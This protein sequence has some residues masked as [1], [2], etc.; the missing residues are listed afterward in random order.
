MADSYKAF[1]DAA[2]AKLGVD[3]SIIATHTR[4][5]TAAGGTKAI[6]QFNYAN[7]KAGS[8]WGGSAVGATVPEFKDGKP[9]SEVAKFRS[10]ASP[11]EAAA[12]YARL[13]STR[14]PGAAGAKTPGDFV[15]ALVK[16]GYAT[17][18]NYQAKFLG[19]ASRTA[20]AG[21]RIAGP[22]A[23]VVE[24]QYGAPARAADPLQEVMPGKAT[25]AKGGPDNGAAAL[26]VLP[27]PREIKGT[28][29][30]AEVQAQATLDRQEA[31]KARVSVLE[32]ARR[33][34]AS[35]GI[36]GAV[37][38]MAA[39]KEVL[40]DNTPDPAFRLDPA[41]L[42]GTD[43]AE[44][45]FLSEA[46]NAK[47]LEHR[48]W[49]V[50]DRRE[51][52]KIVEARGAGYA[53]LA[54]AVSELPTSALLGAGIA[55][56]AGRLGLG[57]ARLLA[58]GRPGAAVGY[59]IGENA[60]ANAAAE[61]IQERIDPFHTWKDA[62]FNMTAGVLFDAALGSPTLIREGALGRRLMAAGE[63]HG[64]Q[65]LAAQ[66]AA[67]AAA[68]A[69]APAAH[70]VVQQQELR[71]SSLD[72]VVAEAPTPLFDA[73]AVLSEPRGDNPLLGVGAD[74]TRTAPAARPARVAGREWV[75][76]VQAAST[77]E[78]AAIATTFPAN[79]IPVSGGT[80][81]P[82]G[83]LA[84]YDP[85]TGKVYAKAGDPAAM[86]ADLLAEVGVKQRLAGVLGDEEYNLAL[87]SV[88][89]LAQR[90]DAIAKAAEAK[91]PGVD[92]L[93]REA[94]LA[95]YIRTSSETSSLTQRVLDTM[96][97]WW[98]KL[99][100]D[101][102]LTRTDLLALIE[103]SMQ[104]E[105]TSMV[106]YHGSPRLFDK[107]ESSKIGTGEG[108]IT[109]G[110]GLYFTQ[111]KGVA[112][113]YRKKEALARGL[114]EDAGTTYKVGLA[115]SRDEL[116][117]W[118]SASQ[119]AVVQAAFSELGLS[120]TGEQAYFSLMKRFSGAPAEQAKQASAVLR[121][122]GVKGN[123]Y[124]SAQGGV[125]NI[126]VFNADDVTIG[127]AFGNEE[128][129]RSLS[130]GPGILQWLRSLFRSS[131]E[132]HVGRPDY[133]WEGWDNKDVWRVREKQFSAGGKHEAV[134]GQITHGQY[135][136]MADLDVLP[137]GITKQAGK[138][139]SAVEKAA[140]QLRAKF[141]G[142]DFK[143]VLMDAD[144][145][146]AGA[147]GAI[148]MIREN[149][150]VIN[151]DLKKSK[152]KQQRVII[153]EIGHAVWQKYL[154]KLTPEMR[155]D[156]DRAYQE[157]RAADPKE[158]ARL[159]YSNTA[160]SA[161]F[162]LGQSKYELS[163]DEFSAE[164]FAKYIEDSVLNG[165]NFLRIDRTFADSLIDAVLGLIKFFK[166]GAKAFRKPADGYADMFEA[167][168]TKQAALNR[169][170]NAVGT[171]APAVRSKMEEPNLHADPDIQ[172]L[173]MHLFPMDT[174]Q[175]RAEVLAI[176]EL[177][178]KAETSNIQ[179]DEKRLSKLLDTA[180]FEDGQ[181][182]ANVLLRA[183]NPVARFVSATLLESPS[184][185]AGRRKTAAI[186]KALHEQAFLG[187]SMNEVQAAYRL[188]RQEAGGSVVEDT[189]G[190]K[191]WG[192]FNA[193]V[194]R[195]IEGRGRGA[196]VGSH[197]Q[198]VKAADSLE[199]A[200]ERMRTAQVQANTV[201]AG[202]LPS[203]SRGYM[204]HRLSQEKIR[205]A[206]TK[207]LSALH[208][209]LTDQFV[210][211]LGFDMSFA[212]ML[213]SKYIDRVKIRALGGAD[214]PAGMAHAGASDVV[215]EAL[216]AAGM[217]DAEVKA[218]LQRI[219]K[220]G[221]GHT[222]KRLQLDLNRTY[223]TPD[224]GT[225]RLGDLFETDQ[226]TLLRAQASRVSG[227]VALSEHGVPGKAG[228]DMIRR[229]LRAGEDGQQATLREVDAFDQVAAEFLGS[230]YG[231]QN[232]VIDRVLQANSLVR[233]GGLA[234]TQLS[235]VINGVVHLGVGRA[236]DSV[237]GIPR[238]IGEVHAL[239]RGEQ[240]NGVLSGMEKLYG[241]EFGTL[242]YKTVFPFDSRSLDP[243]SYGQD[244]LTFMD[245]LLRGGGHLQGK[246]SMWRAIHSAQHRG[247]AEQIA[248]KAVVYLQE[249][250]SA[251]VF[252]R[253]MG[254]SDELLAKLRADLPRMAQFDA[255]GRLLDLDVTKASD[256]D[257]AKEFTQ[258]V[259][260]GVSQII[261]G[262]FIGERSKWATDA[263]MR[264]LTQFR[265]FSLTS[266]EKQWGRQVGNVGTYK[267]LG[268]MIGMMSAAFPIY[269]ARMYA[270]SI[271]RDDR[272]EYLAKAFE[273]RRVAR[274]LMNYGALWGLAPDFIDSLGAIGGWNLGGRQGDQEQDF[275]GNVV[276]PAAGLL[277]D[278]Y[279]AVQNT[280][281]GTD[282]KKAAKVMPGANLPGV[283]QMVNLLGD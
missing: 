226:F 168:L 248:R 202:S 212:D 111:A 10:Y 99:T 225:F 141:L 280:N 122:L 9:V 25:Y 61:G 262:T 265:T 245:R 216:R 144:S 250:K 270:N 93:N 60:A 249:G 32:Q 41:K 273:P 281:E 108:N 133:G 156:V 2:A 45:E 63:A 266:V 196:Q 17:D 160:P 143:I 233:L 44:Y 189:W 23:P 239:A 155:K 107:F 264:L 12:D 14:Y 22:E 124:P 227:E 97:R 29:Q 217:G 145:A 195:E 101:K 102:S 76:T 268:I 153:H 163:R 121:E 232:K 184:G 176:K 218:T 214:T 185:A 34:A 35:S 112:E 88:D 192:E 279:R 204:P 170:S 7:I 15:Q 260:R 261:Q 243:H 89:K 129:A 69:D 1:V 82:N 172:R 219:A 154:A 198:V 203:T 210:T 71:D 241:A 137:A 277:N 272:E 40:G 283:V 174:P 5:E 16:G 151:I 74:L 205:N 190:G 105:R 132:Q 177:Y 194:V 79:V 142:A 114:G 235:E 199:A 19:T 18:P 158:Q 28:D 282:L 91:Y 55:M 230:P 24:P 100:G 67:E 256:L 197:Q 187:N 27:A 57:S 109:Q 267:T 275:V 130:Y 171:G 70:R 242:S 178:R 85:V 94:R 31:D 98:A 175:A 162:K 38:R 3:P 229:A 37:I 213:A 263:H 80:S 4:M 126:V 53:L 181:S 165:G 228:L 231:T 103:S 182:R 251:D 8:A 11:D 39:A 206:G 188:Y 72:A 136:T 58:A 62:V 96:R 180:V 95:E 119:P 148:T 247:M 166:E 47:D 83:R 152:V 115:M 13:L 87:R 193:Q 90:G 113:F 131:P 59:N 75:R 271:G 30:V 146:L 274:Q 26:P 6:G 135:K 73:E 56:A 150:A 255:Q 186:A 209:A 42:V 78:A 208:T 167:I 253:D 238:L 120:G 104:A 220:A 138:D 36:V 106:A 140:E 81:L 159:R 223:D 221:P 173:G 161:T 278:V 149:V 86:R 127:T 123:S 257:A 49:A 65:R 183:K 222:K 43:S 147:D 64:E 68:G 252:L 207:E 164:Q 110:S 246:L 84:A 92:I 169:A 236:M 254:M 50:Q 20:P 134:L 211:D 237:I 234:W 52:Q 224:G 128:A 77:E 259:H 125:R 21:T 157:F 117:T 200:Y 201:G 54:G 116:V 179:V 191:H 244:T 46:M 258:A 215:E 276:A 48:L 269:A 240:V 66:Q 118:E 33:S 51:S 139:F